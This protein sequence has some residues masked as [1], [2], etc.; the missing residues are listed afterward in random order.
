[1]VQHRLDD[2]RVVLA[3]RL[4]GDQRAHVEKAIG[5]ALRIA[6]DGGEIRTDRMAG[7]ERDRQRKE[8]I[9]RG[10]F[11]AAAEAGR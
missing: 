6:I 10:G 3:E 5:L 11:Q 2:G 9:L 8:Q 1:M 4:R 7:I